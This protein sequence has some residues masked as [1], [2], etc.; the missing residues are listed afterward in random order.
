MLQVTDVPDTH[1]EPPT[2]QAAPAAIPSILA[3]VP[4]GPP[5]PVTASTWVETPGWS[6]DLHSLYGRR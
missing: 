2:G 3:L 5:P 4:A 1:D 6:I